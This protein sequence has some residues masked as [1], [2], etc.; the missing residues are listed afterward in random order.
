MPQRAN[1][2][3]KGNEDLSASMYTSFDKNIIDTEGMKRGITC[4]GKQLFKNKGP[5]ISGFP[6][7][8]L[9]L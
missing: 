5:I 4:D 2:V 9:V 8:V 3:A 1:F 7:T 6:E